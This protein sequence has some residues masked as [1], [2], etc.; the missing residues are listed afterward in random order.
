[1]I[2]RLDES[3]IG[4]FRELINSSDIFLKSE[5]HKENWNLFCA[6]MDRIEDAVKVLISRELI[7]NEMGKPEDLV[8]FIV[9]TDIITESLKKIFDR[10][11]LVNPIANRSDIFKQIGYGSGTDDKFFKYIRSLSFAHVVDTS[12][13]RAY[14][15]Q[16]EIKYSPFVSNGSIMD[17]DKI[18]IATYSN[19]EEYDGNFIRFPKKQLIKYTESRYALIKYLN[20]YLKNELLTHREAILKNI[21]EITDNPLETLSNLR[22]ASISR[23]DDDTIRHIDRVLFTL[24]YESVNPMNKTSVEQFKRYIISLINDFVQLYQVLDERADNHEFR[25]VF[26]IQCN[27]K[28]NLTNYVLPKI[29]EYLSEELYGPNDYE[30]DPHIVIESNTPSNVLWGFQQL[31]TF[32]KQLSDK[33]VN[34]EYNM[35]FDEIQLL[36]STALYIDNIQS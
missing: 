6:F 28:Y 24:S 20:E 22:R 11:G 35:P 9:Y 19:I 18:V 34:I 31:K 3:L 10:L 26:Y 21:I 16:G 4:Q 1:M 23:Y 12:R 32:K 27:D 2:P 14:V 5:K 17:T 30:F 29:R 33:H 13:E 36:I 8:I 25:N 15:S 7:T